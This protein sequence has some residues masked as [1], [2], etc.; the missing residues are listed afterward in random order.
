LG[1]EKARKESNTVPPPWGMSGRGIE[2]EW[3]ALGGKKAIYVKKTESLSCEGVFGDNPA[4][5]TSLAR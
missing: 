1:K 3:C 4:C 5:G 2:V